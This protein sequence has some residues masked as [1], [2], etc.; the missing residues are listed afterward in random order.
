[1]CFYQDPKANS[2]SW[3]GAGDMVGGIHRRHSPNGREGQR[4]CVRPDMPFPMSRVY[5]KLREDNTTTIPVPRSP[6]FYGIYNQDG[7][8]SPNSKNEKTWVES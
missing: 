5:D 7:A 2:S 8:E 1:M 6:R 4:P 3:M